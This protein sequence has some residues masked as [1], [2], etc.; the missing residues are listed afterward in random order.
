MTL[1]SSDLQRLAGLSEL[2]L[3]HEGGAVAGVIGKRQSRMIGE[4]DLCLS[5]DFLTPSPP[6]EKTT[7]R[8]QQ[9]RQARA[10]A[11]G[12]ANPAQGMGSG[13]DYYR[14][15]HVV[16]TGGTGALGTAMVGALLE[17][18]A[19]RARRCLKF[20]EIAGIKADGS[21]QDW[22]SLYQQRIGQQTSTSHGAVPARSSATGLADGRAKPSPP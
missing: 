8:Q 13:A 21:A 2:P 7:A 6:A 5:G 22:A 11:T 18:G 1:L 19:A 17:A 3:P 20:C 10:P 4:S 16:V 14:D 12:N 15:R 9:A